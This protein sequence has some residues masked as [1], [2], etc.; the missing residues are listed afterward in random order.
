VDLITE[1]GGPLVAGFIPLIPKLSLN[2]SFTIIAGF[3][4]M[5]FIPQYLLLRYVYDELASLRKPKEK[6]I[7]DE[8]LSCSAIFWGEWNPLANIIQ[9]WT[10]F[11]RQPIALVS[12]SMAFLWLTILSPHDVVFTAYLNSAGYSSEEL[13]IF[14][15][16]GAFV[17]FAGT[18][19]FPFISP[20]FG[21]ERTSLFYIIE[22]GIMITISAVIFTLTHTGVLPA[23]RI[24][25][26]VFLTFVVLSRMG[27]YGFEVGEISILQQGIPE[28]VR[29]RVN[30]VESSLTSLASLLI[31]LGGF[32]GSDPQY[33]VYLVWSSTI[34]ILCGSL[35]FIIWYIK[36]HK[37]YHYLPQIDEVDIDETK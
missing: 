15:G 19:I 14:R 31:F 17:G 36:W 24:W 18:F 10:I 32:I 20:C 6:I 23:I 37:S 4:F 12:I 22:E 26:Y 5:T 28:D 2:F 3:N 30:S 29:G 8:N 35:T 11:W 16:V 7:K 27:L 9:G 33:F 13:G 21:L 34:F 1:I 25:D